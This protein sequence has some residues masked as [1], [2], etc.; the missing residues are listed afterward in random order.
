MTSERK[1]EANRRN[2]KQSTGPKTGDGKARSSRNARQH[3]LSRLKLEDD[4]SSSASLGAITAGFALQLS[5]V[6]TDDLVRAQLWL[7]RIRQA[8][9]DMLAALSECPNPKLAKRLVGLAR[10]ERPARAAQRRVL[11]RW[12]KQG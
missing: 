10:Y 6:D 8:R 4:V 11:K 9:H 12:L 1:I 5:P 3:G 2:A 7:A